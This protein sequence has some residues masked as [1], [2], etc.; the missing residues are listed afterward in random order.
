MTEGGTD[1]EPEVSVCTGKLISESG[2]F[3]VR[4]ACVTQCRQTAAVLNGWALCSKDIFFFYLGKQDP[5]W[6][7]HMDFR[8]GNVTHRIRTDFFLEKSRQP[9]IEL[10]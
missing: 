3:P 8:I 7:K 6:R 4:G 2:K 5:E 10:L 1:S 9:K